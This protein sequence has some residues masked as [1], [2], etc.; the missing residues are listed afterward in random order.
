MNTCEHCGPGLD[1]QPGGY[2]NGTHV[3]A[4]RLLIGCEQEQVAFADCGCHLAMEEDGDVA[5]FT[6]EAH[7]SVGWGGPNDQ[8]RQAT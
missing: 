5:L 1:E 7:N 8:L 2:Y 3:A 4:I 6:C